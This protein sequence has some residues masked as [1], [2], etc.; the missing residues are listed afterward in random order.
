M[1]FASS[2]VYCV[3]SSIRSL[4]RKI[5][6]HKWIN[7]C[8]DASEDNES[9]LALDII[10]CIKDG[11]I[12]MST[13]FAIDIGSHNGLSGSNSYYF[14]K[15]GFK[16]ILV[17]PN[18]IGLNSSKQLYR[19]KTNVRYYNCASGP[20]DGELKIYTRSKN[21]LDAKATALGPIEGLHEDMHER[22]FIDV[23]MVSIS[24]IIEDQKEKYFLDEDDIFGVLS[25]D[26]EGYDLEVLKGLNNKMPIV[27][28]TEFSKSVPELEI[29]KRKWL[30][31]N[32]YYL[33]QTTFSNCI[34][35]QNNAFIKF[36]K[37][38]SQ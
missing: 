5:K 9:S 26:T 2:R 33:Y 15:Q 1:K 36:C 16:T 10:H 24:T 3:L 28:I 22:E 21:A 6:S 31:E 19:N 25:I 8:L 11:E 14:A 35:I 27:V 23:N 37:S 17:E 13:I 34:F 12:N 30:S 18:K 4:A 20:T 32:G 7:L 38:E 29:R